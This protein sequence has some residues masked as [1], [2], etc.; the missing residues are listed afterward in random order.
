MLQHLKNQVNRTFTENNAVTNL[1]TGSHCLDLFATIGALRSASEQEITT[2]FTRAWAE[3]PDLTI[4]ILF[5]ARDIRGGLGERSVF[6]IILRNMATTAPASLLKNLWAIPE[7]GRYDDL[8]VLLDTPLRKDVITF[9]KSQLYMDTTALE[10]G[11]A[12]SLL[13]K[14]LPSINANNKATVRYA[15]LLAKEMGMLEAS[16]RKTLSKL[17][18]HIAIIENNLREMDYTFD[19]EKQPSKAMMKYRKAFLRND[20]ER[21]KGFLSSVAK[22]EAKLNTGTLFPYEII[23]PLINSTISS[24]EQ[25]SID[26]TWNAQD[27]YTN[28][29]NA[30]VVIDGSGSMYGYGNPKPAEVALSLGIYFAERSKGG[31]ANHF[32]TFSQNPRLVEIKGR[33]I[34]EKVQYCRSYNEVA[35]TNIKKV[36]DLILQTAVDNKLSQEE[37][38]ST[39]YII[40]DMEFDSCAVDADITNFEY[41]KK[42]FEAKG[43]ALPIVVFWNVQSRN[44]QQPVTINEQGVVLVSGASPRVFSMLTSG[45]MTPMKYMLETLE[46]QRYS[47][48][49]A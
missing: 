33:N 29:E 35:N 2:R 49:N 24:D 48:I 15:K 23:R 39:L 28:G 36:F 4:K 30:L 20:G 5:Y 37:L 13:G 42:A 12:I 14:W 17:R 25:A 34:S 19:Y 10:D 3:N 27:D 38:P 6:R 32:I 11:K 8:L 31:F 16:Y 45:S 44:Q 9:I 1:S 18:A 47:K 26:A 46:N 21:Y 41:A 22:G 7:Y 43:Y 40:S